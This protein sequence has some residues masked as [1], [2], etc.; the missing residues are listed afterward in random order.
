MATTVRFNPVRLDVIA[1]AGDTPRLR[2]PMTNR[3]TTAPLDLTG[4][5]FDARLLRVAGTVSEP[6]TLTATRTTPDPGYDSV[7]TITF[8]A[9]LEVGAA[10]AT[11]ELKDTL[12]NLTWLSGKISITPD[13]VP[14]DTVPP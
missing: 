11:W 13:T 4:Y 14:P 6:L 3:D 10:V 5:V 9:D 7:L 12:G 1:R 8:P 2:A